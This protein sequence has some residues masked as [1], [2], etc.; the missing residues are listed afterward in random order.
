RPAALRLERSPR[1]QGRSMERSALHPSDQAWTIGPTRLIAWNHV[2]R[3]LRREASAHHMHGHDQRQHPPS[4]V[5]IRAAEPEQP[6]VVVAIYG[7]GGF[8]REVRQLVR[9]LAVTGTRIACAGF[10]VDP[11]YGQPEHL[12]ILG[13][14]AWLQQN[15]EVAVV[16]AIGS[17]A[18]RFRI[19]SRI[20]RDVGSKVVTLVHPRAIV[21]ETITL[22]AGAIACA[23]CV[24]TADIEI[25]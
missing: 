8:A 23:G 10:L 7:A 25:G 4:I 19:A 13:D 16:V 5:T 11:G 2:E 9:E 1:P 15:H 14:A 6:P 24:A 18:A 12:P 17:P 3:R 21:G 22:G 20:E